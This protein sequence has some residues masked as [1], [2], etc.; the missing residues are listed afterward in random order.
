MLHI[1]SLSFTYLLALFDVLIQSI[2]PYALPT[3]NPSYLSMGFPLVP[4]THLLSCFQS[5]SSLHYLPDLTH[6]FPH[7][8]TFILSHSL[9]YFSMQHSMLYLA[10]IQPTHL[11]LTRDHFYLDPSWPQIS[12]SS[13]PHPFPLLHKIALS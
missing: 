13:L 5:I 2:F 4:L 6:F 11:S 1:T 3:A 7:K 9:S 8:S 12:F 10:C